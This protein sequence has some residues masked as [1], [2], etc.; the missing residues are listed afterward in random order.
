MAL[1]TLMSVKAQAGIATA[2]TSRDAQFRSLIDGV[3]SL[4]TQQLNRQLESQDYVEYYS[5]NGS[6]YLMLLQYPVTA[7]SLVSVNDSGDVGVATE[8]DGSWNLVNGVDYALMP[9]ARGL[10][11]SGILRRL[12]TTWPRPS[13]RSCGTLT[14]SPEIPAGNIKVQYT[15]G[16]AVIPPAITMAVNALVLKQAAQAAMGGAASQL[17]Y[18]DAHVGFFSPADAAKT[19]GS[20]ESTLALYRSIPV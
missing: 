18:E 5:G 14:V 7:V 3:T 16:F 2:D 1:T 6:P 17:S 8:N 9:G 19:L 4:V 20:I 13:A 15:A 11:S 12:G 10:G